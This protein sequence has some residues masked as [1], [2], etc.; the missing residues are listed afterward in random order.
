MAAVKILASR[1]SVAEA[2]HQA[3][4]SPGPA[5]LIRCIQRFNLRLGNQFAAAMTYFLVLAIVP[6]A[7]FTFAGLGFVLDVVRP[8]LV[9]L[10]SEELDRIAPG[11]TQLTDQLDSFLNNWQGVG[12]FGIVA[13][14]FT[15]QGF[16]G[17]LRSAVQAQLRDH[18]DEVEKPPFLRTIL[19]NV[20]VLI[21]LIVGILLTVA[22]TVV[23]T[24]MQST[25]V[26]FFDLPAWTKSV[27]VIVPQIVNLGASWLIFMFLFSA[28][29]ASPVDPVAKRRGALIGA[30]SFV[31]LLNLATILV[32]LFSGN[33]A[34]QI[35]GPVI[36][37][38]LA[39]NVF[40]RIIIFVAAW[41]GTA[42]EPPLAEDSS[43]EHRFVEPKVQAQSLGALLAGAGLIALTLLGFRRLDDRRPNEKK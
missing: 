11:N 24:G 42:S 6:I 34:A 39:L 31:V 36:A 41:I 8:D 14:L 2:S 7:M 10:I 32:D 29:P 20:G 25:I 19:G 23:G 43:P 28:L 27:L 37:I 35:F 1:S 9:P 17:N 4:S 26:E 12:I 21:C 38:M 33:K 18:L 16:V 13:G 5:H 22:L 40:A 30:V 15:G 3:I